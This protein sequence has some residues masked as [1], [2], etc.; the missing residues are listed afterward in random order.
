M[1]AVGKRVNTATG[2]GTGRIYGLINPIS[3]CFTI[4]PSV[5]DQIML[6][7]DSITQGGFVDGGF[8]TRLAG[9]DCSILYL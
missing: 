7:G 8:G 3:C 5:Q 9:I 2:L 1:D 6:F 4:M